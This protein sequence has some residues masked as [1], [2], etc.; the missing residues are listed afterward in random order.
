MRYAAFFCAAF[1]AGILGAMSQQ[2]SGTVD[3]FIPSAAAAAP[4]ASPPAAVA[5]AGPAM[6][7]IAMAPAEV[8]VDAHKVKHKAKKASA[9]IKPKPKPGPEIAEAP[10]PHHGWLWRLFHRSE[11]EDG[12]VADASPSIARTGR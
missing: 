3:R 10:K 12:R 4:A 9:R 8:V 2:G 6:T 1:M 5:A 11:D 7:Q